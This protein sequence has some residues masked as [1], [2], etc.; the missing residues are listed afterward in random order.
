M[1]RRSRPKGSNWC[2]HLIC[3]VPNSTGIMPDGALH[4]LVLVCN[5]IINGFQL[6]HEC[7]DVGGLIPVNDLEHPVCLNFDGRKHGSV[8][9]GTIRA[10][11]DE[12]IG[13]VCCGDSKV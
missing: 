4:E 8:A 13:E 2:I 7:V 5:K 6:R 10:K 3:L 11:K 9:D 12:V 1:E